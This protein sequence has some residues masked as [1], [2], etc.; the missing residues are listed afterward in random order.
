MS[1]HIGP[2]WRTSG[3]SWTAFLRRR[4]RQTRGHAAP[5]ARLSILELEQLTA[6]CGGGRVVIRWRDVAR[7]LR[8]CGMDD[9]SMIVI[10]LADLEELVLFSGNDMFAGRK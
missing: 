5:E 10:P 1:R 8:R 7:R 6:S 9:R 2:A 3:E 4:Q